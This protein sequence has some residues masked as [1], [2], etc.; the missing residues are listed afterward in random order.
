MLTRSTDSF[1]VLQVL[2]GVCIQIIRGS[3]LQKGVQALPPWVAE[4][5]VK[6]F[7]F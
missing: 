5:I 1:D 6:P 7:E 4:V 3:A 2:F